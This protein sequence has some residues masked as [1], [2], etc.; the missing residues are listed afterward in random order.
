MSGT[1]QSQYQSSPPGMPEGAPVLRHRVSWA[2]ILAGALVAIA[3]GIALNL[4]GAGIGLTTVDAQARDTPTASTLGIAAG[5]WMLVSNLLGLALGGYVA[6]RLSGTADGQDATLHGAA[7]WA[8]A[9]LISVLLLGSMATS[10]TQTA[11]SAVS[12]VV[13]GIGQA[14]GQAAQSMAPQVDPNA[15]VDRARIALSGPADPARMT[16]EQRGAEIGELVAKRAA[17]GNLSDADRTR[18][19]R[20]VAA[21]AGIPED[22]AGARVRAYEEEAQRT[23]QQAEQRARE[24]ADAAARAASIAAYWGFAVLALGAL[25]A[26]LGARTGTRDLI[27]LTSQRR[28]V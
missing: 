10:A 1:S 23:A 22:E 2:A 3:I 7:V 21:E 15:L 28:M 11:T 25:A 18:L 8:T 9:S 16:P 4:L 19:N 5:I 12:N 13:G 27:H 17:N 20:L 26:I 24:A 6:A 14:A